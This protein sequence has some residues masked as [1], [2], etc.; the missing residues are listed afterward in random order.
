MLASA[1]APTSGTFEQHRDQKGDPVT[2]ATLAD[3][4]RSAGVS[5]STASLAFSGSGP[6]S[7]ATRERVLAAA[8]ELGYSG[9]DPLARSLR[10]G[11]SGVVGVVSAGELTAN[12]RDPVAVRTLDGVAD[13][14]G[15]HEL[16]MLLVRVSNEAEGTDLL[17]RAAMDA[18]I[19][20]HSID[21][22]G[23][24]LT[25]LLA[26]GVPVVLVETRA[27]G[28]S[29]VTTEDAAGTAEL[30]QKVLA[31]GHERIAL[32]TLPW[33]GQVRRGFRDSWDPAEA[34]FAYTSERVRGLLDAGVAPVAVYETSGSLVEEGFA[35]AKELFTLPEPPTVIMALSDLLAAGVLLAAREAGLRVPEDL[36]ITGYDG[37]DLPWL[38]PDVLESVEQ[39]VQRKGQLAGEAAV[40]LIRGGEP[41]EV[42]LGVW[43]RP[44][45]TLAPPTAR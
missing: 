23:P 24:V 41:H 14:L 28:L 10:R 8:R 45:T 31:A 40:A 43:P 42:E 12:F 13:A 11:S 9:P 22:H 19:F 16:G 2:R 27:P 7:A 3:V 37:V 21:P 1:G 20:L 44:G 15:A 17:A 5:P 34:E 26:R 38:A 35:A 18:V 4:A 30:A 6:I 29:S 25:S 36:S 33:T 39:P 32:V